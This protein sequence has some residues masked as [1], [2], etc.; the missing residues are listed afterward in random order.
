MGVL[1]DNLISELGLASTVTRQGATVSGSHTTHHYQSLLRQIH[2]A[3]RKPA[4]YLNRAF[5]LSCSELGGRFT[6]NEYI[7]TV[8]IIHPQL[9][10]DK[11]AAMGGSGSSSD[12]S[13]GEESYRDDKNKNAHIAHEQLPTPVPAHIQNNPHHV[14]LKQAHAVKDVYFTSNAMEG[15]A[16]NSAGHAVTIIIVVCVGFLMFMVVLGVIRVRAAHARHTSED[17][18]DAEMAWDDSSLNITVN[19]MEQQLEMSEAQ[20]LRDDDDDDDDSSDDGSNF[21]DDM[22]SSEDE[23]TPATG[24]GKQKELEWDDKM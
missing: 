3:N 14:E 12:V 18:A 9:S 5:K 24:G 17:A 2:Y 6:S 15:V 11:A 16:V 13:N 20:R 4:Y 7:Q 8:T 23:E 21:N 10:I 1:P 22:D 19:P